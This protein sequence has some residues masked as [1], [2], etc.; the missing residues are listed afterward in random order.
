MLLIVIIIVGL[1]VLCVTDPP[2]E[3]EVYGGTIDKNTSLYRAYLL[4]MRAQEIN[5]EVFKAKTA[6]DFWI[7]NF[8]Y[9][10]ANMLFARGDDNTIE[11][12]PFVDDE[13]LV[14]QVLMDMNFYQGDTE[15]QVADGTKQI[16][17]IFRKTYPTDDMLKSASKHAVMSEY[18]VGLIQKQYPNVTLDQVHALLFRYGA[19]Y[20][21]QDQPGCRNIHISKTCLSIPPPLYQYYNNNLDNV[22]ESFASPV[23]HT[24]DR[25]CAIF[26]DDQEFGAIGPFTEK[27]VA[28]HKG[29]TFIANPPYDSI[30]MDYVYRVLA[31]IESSNYI[32]CL[33]SKD[34][35]LFHKYEGRA[36]HRAEDKETTMNLA[37]MKLLQIDSLSRILIIP[38][39]VMMY[40]SYFKQKK[41]K[42]TNYDTIMMFYINDKNINVTELVDKV[43]D[44]L[45]KYSYGDEYGRQRE[46]HQIVEHKI[47]DLFPKNGPK[48]I[49]SLRIKFGG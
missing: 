17:A 20:T 12:F 22:I 49:D 23:N 8:C 48:I 43:K 27:L 42:V 3:L 14:Y 25:Y 11:N 19:M 6:R 1:F 40:Y 33:P 21:Y 37:L 7:A 38:S 18:A 46:K 24:L 10:M 15:Q 35:G 36:L 34:G 28:K 29:S 32:V 13:D 30:T 31:T 9:S 45:I 4:F 41:E 39:K 44:V 26:K 2:Q 16:L 5:V 47:M